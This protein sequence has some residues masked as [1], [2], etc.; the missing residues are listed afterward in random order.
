MPS[1]IFLCVLCALHSTSTLNAQSVDRIDPPN[2]WVG[3]S[4]SQVELLVHGSNLNSVDVTVKGKG[5][6]L[7]SSIATEN[8]NYRLITLDIAPD[9]TPGNR[10]LVFKGKKKVTVD[11]PIHARTASP[12]GLYPSDF[13]YLIFP[14]RFSN[15][16]AT[17]D[18]IPGTQEDHVDRTQ[19]FH[20]HGGDLAGIGN[21]LDYLTD[22]G[23]TALWLNP[24]YKNDQ[25]K[26]SYHGYAI[27]D[28]YAVD[29]RLGT[30]DEYK[31]LVE[32]CH[33]QG[34]KMIKD[35]IFNH[36][37]SE[38]YFYKD[39]PMASWIHQH[40][41]FVKTSYR[42][43]TL[44]DPYAS[45]Y[46]KNVMAN[47]WFDKHMPDLNQQNPHVSNYLIQQCIWWVEKFNIDGFRIDTYAY[48]DLGF[49]ADL[50]DRMRAEFPNFT[51]FG[52]TWVHGTP[53][54]AFFTEN[55]GFSG[56][57]N[58]KLPGVTDFQLYYAIN[59]SLT[60]PYGWTEG[61]SALY[62]T[63]A[64]D[65]LYED[66]TR[67]VIFLDNHDIHRFYSVIG[68]DF[69]KFK[70]GVGFLL[71]TRGIPMIYY[72][73][74]VLMKNMA[75]PDG[76]VREDFPGGWDGDTLNYFTEEDRT[77][78]VKEAHEFVSHLANYRKQHAALST[79]N[80]TQFI[81]EK[82]VYKYARHNSEE[83]FLIFYNT[84]DTAAPIVTHTMNEII[85]GRQSA[86]NVMTGKLISDITTL[87][88]PA[89][90][91]S[92]YKLEE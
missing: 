45:E 56:N 62:Y 41:S 63:L 79:G 34:I 66:P 47:G 12:Q 8:P 20:R 28:H 19:M 1:R 43:P 10:K 4:Q 77:G 23:V 73:T 91:I 86:T 38:H 13:M 75:D 37:G 11:F 15:G 83:S 17:N 25:P 72:G 92:I 33:N 18:V 16:D 82:G 30:A 80:L 40:D 9:C 74:E 7:I 67:N 39:L 14:D 81:P 87:E 46:D 3:F 27:S 2:W 88:L 57:Y 24:V 36:V 49:M 59:K 90:S 50:S 58:S 60:E 71:T 44:L 51:L 64:K 31:A 65:V 61:V 29:P 85:Q 78:L 84:N 48:S 70:M 68:E 55:N 5:V 22:L 35:V 89:W 53:I 69:N 52:E 76:K 32:K 21:H 42:A 6:E 26:A 54:Q